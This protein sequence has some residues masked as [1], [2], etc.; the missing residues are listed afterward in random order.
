MNQ[1]SIFSDGLRIVKVKADLNKVD[2][3]RA[4]HGWLDK[5]K[6][7]VVSCSR[8]GG[9]WEEKYEVLLPAKAIEELPQELV[10]AIASPITL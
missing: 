2:H 6:G 3:T 10:N 7:S 9:V 5:W 1:P 4:I 8:T